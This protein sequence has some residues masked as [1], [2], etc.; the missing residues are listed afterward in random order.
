MLA[1]KNRT[2]SQADGASVFV[3]LKPVHTRT[4]AKV[5]AFTGFVK[6][7]RLFFRYINFADR[8]LNHFIHLPGPSVKRRLF[9]L[10]PA[11]CPLFA[12]QPFKQFKKNICQKKKQR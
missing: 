12:K 1:E 8:I 5:I 3:F 6:M 7:Q 10:L 9:C 11:L 4:A 2:F